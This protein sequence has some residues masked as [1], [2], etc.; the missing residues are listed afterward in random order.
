VDV[1]GNPIVSSP[2]LV[3]IIPAGASVSYAIIRGGVQAG[4]IYKF[5]ILTADSFGNLLSS[6]TYKRYA[7]KEYSVQIQYLGDLRFNTSSGTVVD[8]KGKAL[9]IAFLNAGIR[10][11]NFAVITLNKPQMD[12]TMSICHQMVHRLRL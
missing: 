1:N 10:Q 3:N 2:L 6:S 7:T 8:K 11:L 9:C 12:P 4:G 5:E